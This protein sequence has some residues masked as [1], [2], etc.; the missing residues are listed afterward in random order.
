MQQNLSRQ[1]LSFPEAADRELVRL[2]NRFQPPVNERHFW[3]VVLAPH[4][5]TDDRLQATQRPVPPGLLGLDLRGD[6]SEVADDELLQLVLVKVDPGVDVLPAGPRRVV[7]VLQIADLVELEEYLQLLLV[8]CALLDLQGLSLLPDLLDLA[9]E[10][11]SQSA[12]LRLDLVDVVLAPFNVLLLLDESLPE[13]PLRAARQV[14]HLPL[15][16]AGVRAAGR[17]FILPRHRIEVLQRHEYEVW[18]LPERLEILVLA[19]AV[20]LAALHALEV[21]RQL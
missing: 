13:L 15:E 7:L 6:V 10:R 16:A 5:P 8:E 14:R 3:R 18:R 19:A 11:L 20:R 9:P 1:L 12:E 17:P 4:E 2:L 21:L